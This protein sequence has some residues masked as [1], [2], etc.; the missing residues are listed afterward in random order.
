MIYALKINYHE[1][2]SF[3]RVERIFFTWEHKFFEYIINDI[4]VRFFFYKERI[5]IVITLF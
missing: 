2:H 4:I 3:K 1:S 5:K